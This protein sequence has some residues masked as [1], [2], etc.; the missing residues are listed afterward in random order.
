[1]IKIIKNILSSNITLLGHLA[2]LLVLIAFIFFGGWLFVL[3]ESRQN[4]LICFDTHRKNLNA[5]FELREKLFN[6]VYFNY[7]KND[8]KNDM[9]ID[10]VLSTVNNFIQDYQKIIVSKT[11][12]KT[13]DDCITQNPWFFVNSVLFAVK[14]C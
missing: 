13:S 3:L 10:R 2:T 4:V 11:L 1:M 8:L 14:F 5:R 9:G 6:F 7:S 12:I